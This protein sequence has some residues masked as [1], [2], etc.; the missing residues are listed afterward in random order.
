M[1][2][3]ILYALAGVTALL[4][5]QC[6]WLYNMYST[7]KTEQQKTVDEL[8]VQS[9]RKEL[10]ARIF[11]PN[12]KQM[13]VKPASSMTKEE[14]E[15]LK[16]DTLDL[17]Q[18]TTQNI[19]QDQTEIFFQVQ[20][21][22]MMQKN[23]IKLSVL[24]S[25]FSLALQSHHLPP[26][27]WIRYTDAT[28]KVLSQTNRQTAL[29]HSIQITARHPIGTKMARFVQAGYTIPLNRILENM[30]YALTLSF[31]IACI[32]AFIIYYMLAE[33]Q[34][35]S[36]E[37]KQNEERIHGMVHDLKSPLN[38]VYLALDSI[39]STSMDDV[40]KK[41]ME[42]GKSRIRHLNDWV[43]F[44]LDGTKGSYHKPLMTKMNL[45]ETVEH[46]WELAKES[47]EK[48]RCIFRISNPESIMEIHC[49]EI[50]LERCLYNLF[51]NALKYSDEGVSIT[52][53]WQR[54]SSELHISVADTGWGME[55]Q[56]KKKIGHPFFRIDQTGKPAIKGYGLGLSSVKQLLKEIHGSLSVESVTGKGST[57][58]LVI[59]E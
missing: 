35:K 23:P 15:S 22:W 26:P 55:Q 27:A 41:I 51:D 37:L 40:E 18:M 31:L 8:F 30:K 11:G 59:P 50:R 12:R 20:Q 24:D 4:L 9:I 58:T 43:A 17:I 45:P 5:L 14:R 25:L 36:R 28:Q 56:Y 49:D 53:S 33:I 29:A 2:R 42:R 7:Y 6:F 19:G 57:F 46:V 32:V 47:H 3:A 16:G 1:R 34:Q 38:S 52:V 54:I 39:A 48:K 44:I 21:D 13:T 10:S